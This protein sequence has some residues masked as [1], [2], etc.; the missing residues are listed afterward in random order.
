MD[1]RGELSVAVRS[2]VITTLCSFDY[3]SNNGSRR[4]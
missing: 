4:W 3:T 1:G 2:D